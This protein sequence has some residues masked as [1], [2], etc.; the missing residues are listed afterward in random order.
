MRDLDEILKGAEAA[1]PGP[2]EYDAVEETL[3]VHHVKHRRPS[4]STQT[5]VTPIYN[6]EVGE[7]D[8]RFIANS[9]TDVA[10]MGAEI[11]RLRAKLFAINE[12]AKGEELTYRGPLWKELRGI[13]I[14]AWAQDLDHTKKA[15]EK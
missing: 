1:T 9:R 14:E 4:G 2:W 5:V 3:V 12:T 6:N 7:N 11:Q 10:E 15:E 13:M 8:S